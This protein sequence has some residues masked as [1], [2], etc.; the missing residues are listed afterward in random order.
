MGATSLAAIFTVAVLLALL[1][2]RLRLPTVLA[3][4]GTG[5]VVG[6][7]GLAWFDGHEHGLEIVAELGVMLLLFTVGLELSL[8]ELMRSWRAVLVGGALQV[9]LSCGLATALGALLG[10]PWREGLVWGY[11]GALSS[12]AVVLRL[13]DARGETKAAHGRLVIG[14]L[15]FQD[16]AVVP[17]MLS[18]PILAG[19]SVS[20]GDLL[21]L[22]GTGA[23]IMVLLTGA[24]V[25]VVPRMLGWIARL[26]NRELFL[27][28]VLAIGGLT[29]WLTSAAG[30]S[31]A[32]GA[33]VAGVVLAETQ[34]SHQALADVLP[35]RAVTMCVFFVS[36]GMLLDPAVL[37]EEPLRTTVLLS[38]IV[39]GKFL[40]VLV[41]GAAL[42]FPVRVAA[43]AAI[44]LAQIGEFS[45][46]L[47]GEASALG[48]VAE[49]DRQLFLA[50]SVLSIATAPLI[51]A[52]FPQFLAGTRALEPLERLLDRSAL[53][54]D[55]QEEVR[56]L[57]DHVVIAGL[58]VGGRTVVTA[59]ERAG[60]EVVII[61]LNPQTVVE[62]RARGRNVVYGDVTS[63][64]VL[65]H[66]GIERARALV[67]V[68][69]D[70]AASH[71]AAEVARALVPRLPIILRTR[72]ASEEGKERVA[73]FEVLSEEFAGATAI[74]STVLRRCGVR[75]WEPIVD[76]IA[77]EHRM[78]PAY[79]EGALGPTPQTAARQEERPD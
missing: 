41:V 26:R 65:H 15:L 3:Y 74:A 5:V 33:F 18:L 28:A 23:L 20:T 50:A 73:G 29:A 76:Q 45:F 63:P 39:V 16:L 77:G 2:D 22:F 58:G 72:F 14:I 49:S 19:G 55:A 51:V 60:L 54:V 31:L 8:R 9:G 57:Q 1:L 75:E 27:L 42:R 68:T 44:A 21:S 6:P 79:E 36:V 7:A 64:E 25:W 47:A 10:M 78:L 30:L 17:M 43:L 61:E 70:L 38:F 24:S 4:V 52:A 71:L 67:L 11:L 32:L 46:V 12:T 37:T 53:Q 40:V 13:L 48:L 62:E 66:A 59:L 34:Y 35:F 69:S 56:D